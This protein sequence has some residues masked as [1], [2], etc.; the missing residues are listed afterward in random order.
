METKISKAQIAK[1]WTIAQRHGLDSDAV[2]SILAELVPNAKRKDDGSVSL[3]SLTKKQGWY[4]IASLDRYNSRIPATKRISKEADVITIITPA[5]VEVIRNI[6]AEINSFESMQIDAYAFA[7]RAYKSEFKM[8]SR[9]QGQAM[10]EALKSIRERIK[11][12]AQAADN[13]G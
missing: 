10:I 13:L 2:Y 3:S 9:F 4:V 5:Q 1:I 8:L 7:R 12:A 11:K 6:I